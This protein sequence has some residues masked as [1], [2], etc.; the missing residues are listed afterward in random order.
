[1]KTYHQKRFWIYWPLAWLV[2]FVV[3][4]V[5]G[6]V[7][8]PLDFDPG[9]VKLIQSLENNWLYA[10]L[11]VASIIFPFLLSFDKNVHFYTNWSPLFKATAIVALFFI[12]WDIVFTAA[13]VWGFNDRY[14]F[15]IS[16][17]GLPL[18]EWL[19]FFII[20]YCCIFIYECLN[21]YIKKDP[22]I[23]IQHYITWILIPVFVFIG[24]YN[25][26]NLYTSLTFLSAGGITFYHHFFH[27]PAERSRFYLAWIV[28]IIP[29]FFIN[30]ALTGA[31]T[32][33]PI[34]VYSPS[35]FSGIRWTTIPVDDAIYLYVFLLWIIT[36]YESFKPKKNTVK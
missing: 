4:M 18:E 12:V 8:Q 27:A 13:G 20:P 21:F 10:F 24:F 15:G 36:I 2:L 22:L 17:A 33:E 16:L 19:W 25:W 1:M 23:K 35:E 29:F 26:G 5:T 30:G 28:S 11:L 14:Y 9:T 32:Q 6:H 3:V 7:E 34:V 31:F